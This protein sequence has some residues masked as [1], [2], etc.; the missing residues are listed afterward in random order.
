LMLR[1]EDL[2]FDQSLLNI[3]V[4]K[5]RKQRVIPMSPALSKTLFRYIQ[6]RDIPAN[7]LIFGSKK[8]HSPRSK[9]KNPTSQHAYRKNVQFKC[10]P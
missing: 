8:N 7:N 5:G 1:A 2:N 4:G 9:L 10:C 3:Y 6:R